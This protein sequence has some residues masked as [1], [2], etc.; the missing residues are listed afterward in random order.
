MLDWVWN[1]WPILLV[2]AMIIATFTLIQHLAGRT[3][4]PYVARER[5]VTKSE[6]LFFHELRTAVDGDWEIFGMVRIADILKVPKGIKQRR[7]WLNKILSKHID[8]VLC[9]SDTLEVMVAIE[10]DDPSHNRPHRIERDQFVNTA[11]ADAGIP[12][13]RIPTQAAYDPAVLRKMIDRE[14]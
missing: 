6:L 2:A 9:D 11:F 13:L 4:T 14:V 7:A 10:L 1:L 12:L 8:F 3:T 5:L